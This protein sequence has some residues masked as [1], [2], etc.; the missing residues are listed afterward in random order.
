MSDTSSSVLSSVTFREGPGLRE[1]SQRGA[2]SGDGLC[3]RR[4]GSVLINVLT[5]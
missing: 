4:Q 5:C 2:H 3:L 1:S